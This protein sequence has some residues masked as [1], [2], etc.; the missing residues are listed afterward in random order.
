[1]LPFVNMS[2][3]KNDEYLSD[4]MTEELLNVLAKVTGLRVP[5]RSSSF[6]FKGKNEQDIFRKV[7]DQ[8]HVDTVLEGSVRKAGDK[9]RITA[10]LIN[11]TDGYHLW[12]ETYDGDMKDILALQSDVA[13]RVVQALQV[14]LGVD[15]ATRAGE[16]TD[17]ECGSLPALPAGPL[18]FR[19]VHANRL[20]QCDP[21]LRAS[22]ASRS[23]LRASLIAGWPTLTAGPEDRLCRARKRGPKKRNWR[24][25]RWRS[26]R[27]SLKRTS[28]WAAALFSA[29]NSDASEKELDRAVELNP[30]LALAYDQYGWTYWRWAVSMRRSRR[31]RRRWNSIR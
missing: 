16:E 30:N 15:E 26:I 4:G 24:K 31:R 12:S 1:M 28:R 9:L 27:I 20:D 10:Q 17:R 8:L 22:A 18:P 25:K 5:G 14:K 3:D 13:Q 11:V 6:A 29:L 19:Q 23:Q 21:L 2:A 7:G